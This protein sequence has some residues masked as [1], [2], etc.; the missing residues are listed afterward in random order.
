[1]Y[2]FASIVKSA[3]EYVVI[4]YIASDIPT[5]TTDALGDELLTSWMVEMNE[6][7]AEEGEDDIEPTSSN[8]KAKNGDMMAFHDTCVVCEVQTKMSHA[9]SEGNVAKFNRCSSPV[10]CVVRRSVIFDIV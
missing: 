7:D 6:D 8:R 1:M 4:F 5:E 10:V 2:K 9:K 3:V